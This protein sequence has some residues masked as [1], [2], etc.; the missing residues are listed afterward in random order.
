MTM[1]VVR[2]WG[3]VLLLATA[4]LLLQQGAW[5]HALQH[6]AHNA[7]HESHQQHAQGVCSLCLSLNAAQAALPAVATWVLP[8]TLTLEARPRWTPLS[9]R[10]TPP[11]RPR[12][13]APP[14][15]AL[16]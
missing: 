16:H 15:T 14:L 2:R 8:P 12:T 11:W 9:H 10:P 1:R 3:L 5:R 7:P 6:D 13:R 4:W